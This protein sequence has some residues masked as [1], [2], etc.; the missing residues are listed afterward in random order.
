MLSQL[1]YYSIT[2]VIVSD[3]VITEIL[4][5]SRKNNAALEIT[6]CLLYHNYIFLQLLEGEKENVNELFETIKKDERHSNVTL[7]IEEN[8]NERMYPN[9]SMA[10]HDFRAK[11]SAKDNF[12]K[13]IDFSSNNIPKKTE[14]IDLF[15]RMAK[16]IVV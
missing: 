15:W 12:V 14:A 5:S 13:S 6:G 11:K 4:E 9:W 7:I 10:Y 3:K 1:V 8:I 16:Q 2:N